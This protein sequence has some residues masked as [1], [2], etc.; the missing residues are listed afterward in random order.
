MKMD[1][2]KDRW[3]GYKYY[4]C[5]MLISGDCDP[6]YPMLRYIADRFELNMEQR[7]WLAF[8][9]AASYCGPTAYYILNEFPDYENA[10]AGRMQRWWE[11]NKQRCVFQTDRL[12]VKTQN[13]LVRMFESYRSFCGENQEQKFRSMLSG[14][15]MESYES[16]YAECRNL[17]YYGR[18]SL[19]LLLEAVHVLTGLPITPT[20]VPWKEA[21]SSRNGLFY[22]INREDRLDQNLTDEDVKVLEDA[23][24]KVLEE[25]NRE[26]PQY[27]HN[28][29]NIET[30]LC[31]YKKLWRNKRYLG[32]YI[33]R[34]QAEISKMEENVNVGVSW[35]PLWDFRYEYFSHRMLG[36]IGGWDGVRNNRMDFFTRTGEFIEPD[37]MVDDI[38]HMEVPFAEVDKVYAFR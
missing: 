13:Q 8:L 18:Y 29:W 22:A 9:Y 4:H 32:Y 36:E 30:T 23:E 26:F 1:F 12:R 21:L 24:Y 2:R 31:A 5:M 33:D 17:Y 14:N 19:F 35:S 7:Y 16:V 38:I 34:Q 15:K 28:A 10:D 37:L 11:K 27:E 6:A 3:V 25:L 20:T